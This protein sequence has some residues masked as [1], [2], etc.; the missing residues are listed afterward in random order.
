LR[1]TS[2]Y[3]ISKKDQEEMSLVVGKAYGL[4]TVALRYF[5][6]YGPRQSLSNPYTGVCALFSSRIKNNNPPVIYED[7]LQTRD[8]LSVKDIV[9]ANILA[10]EKSAANYNVYNVGSGSPTSILKIAEVLIK[11]YGSKLKPEVTRKYRKGDIRHCYA[12]ISRISKDLGYAPTVTFEQGMKE[13]VGWGKKQ[14]SRDMFENA[15]RELEH[16]GLIV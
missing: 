6:V 1:S 4:P 12:D 9:Q 14:E 11:L 5:N 15:S 10:L 7:G 16:K 13:L 3:A 2:I 8:F